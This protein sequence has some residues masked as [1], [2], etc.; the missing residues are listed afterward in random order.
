ML[1]FQ[2]NAILSHSQAL[3][4]SEGAENLGTRQKIHVCQKLLITIIIW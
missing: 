4:I 2:I 3:E 1:I